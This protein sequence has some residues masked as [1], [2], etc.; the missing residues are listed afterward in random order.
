MHSRK[1]DR[2]DARKFYTKYLDL[3]GVPLVAS[4]EVADEALLRDYDIVT[5]MLAGRLDILHEMAVGGTHL[6]IIGKDQ[7][8]IDMPEYNHAPNAAYLNERVRG[9]GGFQVTSFGEENLLCLP[10][11]RYDTESIAVH[12]FCHTIDSALRRID[13]TWNTRLR[14]TFHDA[15]NKG[16]WK[17]T[18]TGSNPAEYWAEACQMYFDCDRANNW[19]HGPNRA[20]RATQDL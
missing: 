5:H 1:S 15:V 11:D 9:T 18:Y 12:E 20:A 16:L 2:A 7:L 13:P 14:K 17:D 3:K 19:N 8:Y 10:T 4:G 6:I